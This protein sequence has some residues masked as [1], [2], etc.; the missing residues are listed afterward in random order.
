MLV[1]A[2]RRVFQR[3]SKVSDLEPSGPTPEEF[4]T[5]LEFIDKVL[6]IFLH[7]DKP[8]ED[9]YLDRQELNALLTLIETID[10]EAP[11][12][13]E[14]D[15]FLELIKDFN[16]PEERAAKGLS[17]EGLRTLFEY[18]KEEVEEKVFE[19]IRSNLRSAEEEKVPDSKTAEATMRCPLQLWMAMTSRTLRRLPPPPNVSWPVILRSMRSSAAWPKSKAASRKPCSVTTSQLFAPLPLSE[20]PCGMRLQRKQERLQRRNPK[21]L[22]QFQLHPPHRPSEVAVGSFRPHPKCNT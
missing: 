19:S 20:I 11:P 3:S 16:P 22:S 6:F 18:A 8:S 13:L 2:C 7:F 12:P 9:E 1:H 15:D 14:E 21:R 4:E 17:L 5:E 10:P